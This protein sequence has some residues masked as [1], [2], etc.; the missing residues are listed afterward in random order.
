MIFSA[1]FMASGIAQIPL[2][3]FWKMEK[4][5]MALVLARIRQI[6]LLVA[7]IYRWYKGVDFTSGSS[8]SIVAFMLIIASVVLSATAQRRHVQ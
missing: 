3:L 4:L 5:S 8:V 1:T 7:V 2:Q 6:G